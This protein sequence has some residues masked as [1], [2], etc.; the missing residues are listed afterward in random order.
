MKNVFSALIL[1]CI[2]FHTYAQAPQAFRYQAI[3]RDAAGNI[4]SG[5]TVGLR[6]SILQGS[7]EGLAVYSEVHQVQ[8]NNFGLITIDVGEGR[9]ENGN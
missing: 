8:T 9:Q 3:A 6:I 5:Q 1:A 4:L 2:V 7:R